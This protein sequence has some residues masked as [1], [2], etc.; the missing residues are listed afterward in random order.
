MMEAGRKEKEVRGKSKEEGTRK[1]GRE[2]GKNEEG[3]EGLE[4]WPED[5][6]IMTRRTRMEHGEWRTEG[7]EKSDQ[8]TRRGKARSKKNVGDSIYVSR[9]SSS[10]SSWV[11]TSDLGPSQ[12]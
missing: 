6:T 7:G 3:F 4:D 9:L 2:E 12:G 10:S 11:L 5:R 8:N 1:E